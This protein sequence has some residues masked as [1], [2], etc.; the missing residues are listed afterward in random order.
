MERKPEHNYTDFSVITMILRLVIGILF[1]VAA[2]NKFF[3]PGLNGFKGYIANQ[4]AET[5]LPNFLLVPYAYMVP[6]AELILGALLVIG[7]FTRQIVLL[8][9]FLMVSLMFGMVL[10]KEYA[11]VANNA[12]YAVFLCLA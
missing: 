11:T 7:L 4:F 9:A 10:L 5:W 1:F 12:Q 2:L 3:G 8:S 6:F